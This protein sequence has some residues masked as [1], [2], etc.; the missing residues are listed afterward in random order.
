MSGYYYIDDPK[1]NLG[2]TPIPEE[3]F[4]QA[5]LSLARKHGLKITDEMI[6][7]EVQKG[8]LKS[9]KPRMVNTRGR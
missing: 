6:L 3:E 4:S 9:K 8:G 1:S 7:K 5:I 2:Y